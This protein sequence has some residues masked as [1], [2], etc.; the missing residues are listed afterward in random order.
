MTLLDERLQQKGPMILQLGMGHLLSTGKVFNPGK[1]VVA[2]DISDASLIEL[3]GQPEPTVQTKV[4]GKGKP[5]LQTQVQ[6][7]QLFVQKIEVKMQALAW[8]QTQ[9]QL[10]L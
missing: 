8:F 7:T 3:A 9:H 2:L 6:Q 4:N 5:G 10:L 1:A